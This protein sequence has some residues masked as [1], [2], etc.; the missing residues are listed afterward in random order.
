VSN[1][2]CSIKASRRLGRDGARTLYGYDANS[3]RVTLTDSV[4]MAADLDAMATTSDYQQSLQQNLQIDSASNRLL[5]VTQ[6]VSKTGGATNS[7]STSTG[8]F[9]LDAAGNLLSYGTR[10]FEYNGA[11]R[12]SKTT[13]STMGRTAHTHYSHNA[14]G[15][16]VFKTEPVQ[17]TA[18]AG[19]GPTGSFFLWLRRIFPTLPFPA[20][21]NSQNLGNAYI[22]G[23]GPLGQHTLLGEY[24]TGGMGL[25]PGNEIIWLP[26]DGGLAMPIGLVSAQRLYAVH[27]D[28]IL[29]PRLITNDR[30]L[31]VWQWPYSAFGDNRPTGVLKSIPD[32]RP[33]QTADQQLLRAT[34]PALL[35]NLRY[36]GQY[37]DE[38]AGL[39]YNYFRSYQAATGRYTQPDPIGLAGGMNLFAYVGGNPI[40]FSDP[41]GLETLLCARELGG[42]SSSPH[43]PSGNPLRHDYLVVD[44]KVYS[45]LPGA[46][47]SSDIVWS[48]GRISNDESTGNGHCKS[49]SK[50]PRFDRAV[51]RAIN[52]IGRPKY[53]VW[54]YP[55]TV[56]HAIGAR[57]CQT[58]AENVL[59]PAVEIQKP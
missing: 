13:N 9:A 51:G 45:F 16:R 10:R 27:A 32:P 58:W 43:P 41:T 30:N 18:V 29:T 2:R 56:T 53:N 40:S 5:G 17:E 14:M 21:F 50:D 31:P 20:G 39:N 11:N 34:T 23:D 36:P 44:G 15:Q 19:G 7:S 35:F 22:Y 42:P 49:V 26:I 6:V 57:N 37:F 48:Q 28:H 33:G 24:G 47:A 38:E 54:A 4:D 59:R 46:A 12:L 55:R 25:A 8:N 52:E 1:T 3:N